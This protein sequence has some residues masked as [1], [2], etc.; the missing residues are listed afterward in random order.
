MSL[1]VSIWTK[2]LHSI[3]NYAWSIYVLLAIFL[4]GFDLTMIFIYCHFYSPSK[5]FPETYSKALFFCEGLMYIYR[6][7]LQSISKTHL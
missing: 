3:E 7:A 1:Y 6:L 2:N 5:D 4:H